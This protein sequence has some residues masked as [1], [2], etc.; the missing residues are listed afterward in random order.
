MIATAGLIYRRHLFS[1]QWLDTHKMPKILQA[2]LSY[3][4]ALLHVL[5][6]QHSRAISLFHFHL[7]KL[8][9]RNCNWIKL[10]CKFYSPLYKKLPLLCSSKL[11]GL[12]LHNAQN[13]N[14]SIL[15]NENWVVSSEWERNT[16]ME[17]TNWFFW[18]RVVSSPLT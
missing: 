4:P 8:H 6:N 16:A 12:K 13:K 1:R 18:T 17:T 11:M 5:Y 10:I 14:F 7:V 9:L 2:F 15:D 3:V